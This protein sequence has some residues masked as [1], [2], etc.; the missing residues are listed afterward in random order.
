MARLKASRWAHPFV[1]GALRGVVAA[2]NIGDLDPSVRVARGL[3]EWFAR[4]GLNAQRVQRAIDNLSWC[5]PDWPQEQVRA[6]A[7]ESYKSLFGL[8]AELAVLPRLLTDDGWATR[9]RLGRVDV[10]VDTLMRRRACIL[11]TGHCGNWE[12]LGYCLG[13]LGFRVHAL[14]RPLDL[15]PADRWLRATRAR[16]GL[17]LIDKFGATERAPEIIGRGESLAF[18][19]DQN[20]GDRGLFVPFFDRLA[21]SYKSIGLL[22]MRFNLPVVCGHAWRIGGPDRDSL[23]YRVD[24]GDVISPE[25]WEGQSDPLFYITARYRRAIESMVRSA[26]DQYL[27][28]HRYWKSRPRFERLGKPFPD[29]LRAKLTSLPWMTDTSLARIE[30][31][32]AQDAADL[33]RTA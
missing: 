17:E 29:A 21:S 32:S 26:P 30:A 5:F 1:Y 18:I 27:W 31:R 16:R 28:M 19:A 14:Y 2:A 10:G 7:L 15:A 9:V 8:A 22:A 11:I 20:A 6:C 12:L 3:G 23:E 13:A 24:I 4:S 33:R 25:D